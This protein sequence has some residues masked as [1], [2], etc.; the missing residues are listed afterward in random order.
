MIDFRGVALRV[1]QKDTGAVC[2]TLAHPDREFSIVLYNSPNADDVVA[3]WQAWAKMLRRPLLVTDDNGRLH[4][5]FA[6]L[7]DVRVG[8]TSP[9]RRR[10]TAMRGRRPSIAWRRRNGLAVKTVHRGER[11]IISR[12]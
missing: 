1:I 9:R 12:N 4:E 6:Q 10:R 7:G 3:E 2:V 5:L 11:E 8:K